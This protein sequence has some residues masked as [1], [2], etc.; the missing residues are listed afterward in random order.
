[1]AAREGAVV[2]IGDCIGGIVGG[3]D[4]VWMEHGYDGVIMM[5]MVNGDM[6]GGDEQS[7][8]TGRYAYTQI[9]IYIYIGI[10]RYI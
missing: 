7:W 10:Y 3:E 5:M 8:W 2:M 6:R 1:M 4:G 9:G